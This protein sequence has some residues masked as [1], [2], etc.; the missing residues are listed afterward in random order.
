MTGFDELADGTYTAVVDSIED[1]VATIFIE[2]DGEEIGHATCEATEL[3]ADGR[4][5]DAI[6][7][8]TVVNGSPLRWTPDPE[9]SL[10]RTEAA[11]DRF[12]RLSER[13][14]SDEDTE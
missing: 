9:R 11:Q 13:P 10:E 1:G 6:L 8:V 7:L 4:Q 3:P 12:D 5:A 2:E 14:P